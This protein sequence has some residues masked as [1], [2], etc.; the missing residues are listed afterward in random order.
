MLLAPQ[1]RTNYNAPSGKRATIYVNTS[2]STMLHHAGYGR[3]ASVHLYYVMANMLQPTP[4]Q[5]HSEAAPSNTS[6][7]DAV[8]GS[9]S[10]P[11]STHDSGIEVSPTDPPPL[12]RG[13]PPSRRY[14]IYPPNINGHGRLV[15]AHRT[16]PHLIG[17]VLVLGVFAW[18][19]CS[20]MYVYR[21]LGGHVHDEMP[22]H[23]QV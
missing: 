7:R 14:Y 1:H 12:E 3:Y 8:Y 11:S 6:F 18:G 9:I 10:P 13:Y 16:V 2:S 21:F 15:P 5:S 4:T 23:N 20:A 19:V 17:L 22:G